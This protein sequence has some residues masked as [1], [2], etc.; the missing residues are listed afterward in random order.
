[1]Y[2]FAIGVLSLDH[3]FLKNLAKEK[4]ISFED[5]EELCKNKVN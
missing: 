2:S 5:L 1:L 4:Q 3:E